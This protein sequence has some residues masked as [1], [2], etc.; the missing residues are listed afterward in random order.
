VRVVE[1]HIIGEDCPVENQPFM[2]SPPACL[3]TGFGFV[4]GF[5]VG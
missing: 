2:C 1:E 5:E 3:E 4:S